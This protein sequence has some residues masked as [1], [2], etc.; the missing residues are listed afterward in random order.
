MASI[1]DPLRDLELRRLQLEEQI[2]KLRK[3]LRH[4]QTWDAEYEGLKEEL[5]NLSND[6]SR[7]D[8]LNVGKE[9]GGTLVNKAEIES[10]I[11]S[12]SLN[13]SKTQVV[14]LLARRIVYVQQ[15]VKTVEKQLEAAEEKLK[16][17]LVVQK[18]D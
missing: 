12:A 1:R 3:S 15:K 9:F 8:I 17:L 7:K 14:S 10:L 18:P 2:S 11:G 13:R 4:W 5:G 6:S 16:S